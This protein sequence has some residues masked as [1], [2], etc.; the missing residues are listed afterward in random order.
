MYVLCLDFLND[1][2]YFRFGDW[3]IVSR[4]PRNYLYRVSFSRTRGRFVLVLNGRMT[5]HRPSVGDMIIGCSDAGVVERLLVVMDNVVEIRNS[6]F[7][8][9][10]IVTAWYGWYTGRVREDNFEIY[11]SLLQAIV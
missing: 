2:A 10:S 9:G 8:P 5:L 7:V 6:V 1:F 4:R 11:R 3:P